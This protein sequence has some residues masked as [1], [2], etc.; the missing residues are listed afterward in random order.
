MAAAALTTFACAVCFEELPASARAPLMPCCGVASSTVVFC[1]RCV[2]IICER[3]VR[4]IG[5]CP[6]C[7]SSIEF[8]GGA[9]VQRA[10]RIGRCGI[11]LQPRELVGES[12]W[13]D[14]CALGRA[15]ALRYECERCGCYQRIAHPMYRYQATAAEFGTTTWACNQRCGAQRNWRVV[16]D[17]A[18]LVPAADCPPGWGRRS[19]WLAAVRDQRRREMLGAPAALSPW[20]C[21]LS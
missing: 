11:C 17:D 10:A 18:Y 16:P 20:A 7:S 15:N 13:C 5:R 21:A 8:V 14:A 2:E 12:N 4:G 19:A 9:L 1:R 6:T 3:G